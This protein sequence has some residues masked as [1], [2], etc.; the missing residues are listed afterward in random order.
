MLGGIGGS[1][2]GAGRP[3]QLLIYR[4]TQLESHPPAIQLVLVA[5]VLE[6]VGIR[7]PGDEVS[8]YAIVKPTV[9]GGNTFYRGDAARGIMLCATEIKAP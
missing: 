2:K 1:I 3:T 8:G 6:D 7:R 4:A 5:E 9:A